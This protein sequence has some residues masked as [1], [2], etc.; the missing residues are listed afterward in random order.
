M[1]FHSENIL[2]LS[3]SQ[4]TKRKD[5]HLDRSINPGSKKYEPLLYK[6][7]INFG[8]SD[9]ETIALV[10]QVESH[11]NSFCTDSY[12]FGLKI[13]LSKI[14]VRQC[15]FKI[16]GILFSQNTTFEIKP[17][18]LGY[19]SSNQ[20]S[21]HSCIQNMP[22]SLRT[23]YILKSAIGF[24]EIEIAEILNVSSFKIKDR[25]QEAKFFLN[26]F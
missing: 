10:E 16:S 14:M 22:L 4:K 7:G 17:R 18:V 19:H 24:D 2:S 9:G 20:E 3:A 23:V 26:N 11:R 12:T 8:F 21:T 6:I 13:W 5:I 1:S 15:I 25:F